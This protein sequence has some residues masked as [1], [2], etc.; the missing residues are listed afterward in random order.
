M[1]LYYK[2]WTFFYTV[3]FAG[4]LMLAAGLTYRIIFYF[5][6]NRPSLY[7]NPKGRLMVRAFFRYVL[8]QKQLFSLSPVR[9]FS[10]MAVF[11]GFMGLLLLSAI[12]VA[13]ETIV[14]SG[15]AISHYMLQGQGRN[16]Y[17][18]AGDLFGLLMLAGLSVAFVRRFII[19]DRQLCTDSTDTMALIIL[20]VLV[21]TGFLLEAARISL[22]PESPAL[23][24][25]FV[26]Y[27]LSV[28]FKNTSSTAELAT[29]L[30]VVH[31][32][33][34]AFFLAYIPHSKFLHIINSPLEIM[35]SASE[36]RMRDD[37]YL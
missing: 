11:Y 22:T 17:K 31:S 14:P 24:Y 32:L 21:A 13:L 9:W 19:R 23:H 4:L 34:T 2:P 20:L 10:H 37:L 3:Q 6:G 33:L 27:Q 35:M 7:K 5:R 36:E 30:W 26:G 16:C 8:L 18:A 25:S 29:F 12:A 1:E 15:S 28:L